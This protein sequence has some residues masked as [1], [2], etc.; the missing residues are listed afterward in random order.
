MHSRHCFRVAA[1][2]RKELTVEAKA[3]PEENGSVGP[4]E[5][6]PGNGVVDEASASDAKKTEE[7][8]AQTDA[9]ENIFFE[10]S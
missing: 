2:L 5:G 3:L 9:L 1:E 7:V 4:S 10:Q 6:A 8:G